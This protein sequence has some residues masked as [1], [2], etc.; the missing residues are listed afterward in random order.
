[1]QMNAI[2]AAA[3]LAFTS[4][5][6]AHMRLKNPVPFAGV[7]QAPLAENGGNFPCGGGY[8]VQ[9]MNTWAAGSTQ[10]IEFL[11]SAVHSGGSCQFAFTTD[12]TPSP[13][14]SWKVIHSVIGGCPKN[15]EGNLPADAEGTGADKFP[16]TIPKETP[17]GQLTFAWIW[18]NK[19]GNREMYMKCAPVT[20]T[21]VAADASAFNSFPDIFKAN[22]GN[23]CTTLEGQ[24]VNFP[25]PGAATSS[26][27][28]AGSPGF[29]G[30]CGGG[31]PSGG[32]PV[33]APAPAPAPVP[34][35]AP[36]PA[37]APGGGA[38]G[39]DGSLVCF[40]PTQFGICNFGSAIAQ[41]VAQGTTCSNGAIVRRS[42]Q[43]ARRHGSSILRR[44]ASHFKA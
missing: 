4:G 24:N 39:A 27:G 20:V 17:S 33:P 42:V 11:G 41:P 29:T 30:S 35:P 25:N 34:A 16:I 21:G 15:I 22:I 28:P 12:A 37:P 6:N 7:D 14:S 9:T 8:T 32:A 40:G 19:T 10:T 5:A 36:A 26:N 13:S 44:H 31:A 43:P 1:M 23:G 2:L 3:I 38:C 18:F